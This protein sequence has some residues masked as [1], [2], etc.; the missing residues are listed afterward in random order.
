M[1]QPSKILVVDDE[2]DVANEI[3]RIIGKKEEYSVEIAHSGD[4]AIEKLKNSDFDVILLDIRMPQKSGIETLKEMRGL[5]KSFEAVMVTALD[6]ART[7]W[8]VSQVG[9]FDYITKPFKNEDLL[10]RLKM[11]V[12]R[13]KESEQYRDIRNF[14]KMK[15]ENPEEYQKILDEWAEYSSKK[16]GPLLLGLEEIRFVLQQRQ[17]DPEWFKK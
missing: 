9:A 6:D 15:S 2:P 4:E 1:T 11:A 7:A 17:L 14:L 10:L 5:G 16:G 12:E 13:K 8:E 3:A